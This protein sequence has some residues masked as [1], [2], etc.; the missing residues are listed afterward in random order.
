MIFSGLAV[1]RADGSDAVSNGVVTKAGVAD[2]EENLQVLG[3]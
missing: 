1:T 2:D 3:D